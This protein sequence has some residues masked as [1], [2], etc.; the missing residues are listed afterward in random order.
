MGFFIAVPAGTGLS[1]KWPLGLAP[2]LRKE[3]LT[4]Q[5]LHRPA[6]HLHRFT[7]VLAG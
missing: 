2:P 3:V 1:L 7:A 6:S 5:L 4:I